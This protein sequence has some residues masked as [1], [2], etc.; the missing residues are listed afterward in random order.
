MTKYVM[1]LL[2]CCKSKEPYDFNFPFMKYTT[3]KG[4]LKI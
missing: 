3:P 4:S 2:S 1:L